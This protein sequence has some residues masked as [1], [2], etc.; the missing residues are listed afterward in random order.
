MTDSSFPAWLAAQAAGLSR[1]LVE[2]DCGERLLDLAGHDYLGLARDPR[3]VAGAVA[4]AQAYG[5]GASA[6][7]LVSG[8]LPIH[9]KLEQAMAVLGCTRGAGDLPAG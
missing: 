4:A 7:R 5:A 1:R 3:V 8:T 9:T 2:V 6:S